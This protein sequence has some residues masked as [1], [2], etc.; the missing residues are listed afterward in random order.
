MRILINEQLSEH[1]YKTPEGYLICTD[2]IIARTGKQEYRKNEIFADS[3]DDSVIELDRPANEVFSEKTIA[4]FENKPLVNEHPNEDV[5]TEN[6]KDYAVGFIRDVHKG[7]VNGQDVLLA[8]LVFTDKEAIE[9]IESG[10]KNELSCGYDC[11]IV[12][13]A[14]PKQINIR[15]NHVALCERGRAGIAKIVDS[16]KDAE[17]IEGRT[18]T[19]KGGTKLKIKKII[20]SY[21]DYNGE[22]A[23]KIYY[24]YETAS[25][26]TGSAE[27]NS[28]DFFNMM[29]DTT[30]DS[31]KDDRYII[32]RK[33]GAGEEIYSSDNKQDVLDELESLG[34]NYMVYD[35]KTKKTYSIKEFKSTNDSVNDA[36]FTPK[37]M[38]QINHYADISS[39][40]KQEI[41]DAIM[42]LYN[43][44]IYADFDDCVEE[45][46]NNIIN[47]NYLLDSVN[48]IEIKLENGTVI[49]PQQRRDITEEIFDI[50]K[51]YHQK[52][53]DFVEIKNE[54]DIYIRNAY[55]RRASDRELEEAIEKAYK[56]FGYSLDDSI[57][58]KDIKSFF[59][60]CSVDG[61]Y[62]V[63]ADPNKIEKL[64]PKKVW[65]LER[66]GG[67]FIDMSGGQMKYFNKEQGNPDTAKDYVN[68][69]PSMNL[70]DSIQDVNPRSGESKEDFI[71]RFMSE[72][73]NEYPDEKQRL[74]VAYSYWEKGK[75]KDSM[76]KDYAVEVLTSDGR[77]YD[78]VKINY[79][80]SYDSERILREFYSKHPEYKDDIYKVQIVQDSVKDNSINDK[81]SYANYYNGNEFV[82]KI[83][84]L[85]YRNLK[86]E[87]NVALLGLKEDILVISKKYMSKEYLSENNL[88]DIKNLLE[89]EVNVKNVRY[90][91]PGTSN[92]EVS[93]N[94]IKFVGYN[95]TLRKDSLT[96]YER[97]LCD[98]MLENTYERGMTPERLWRKMI[99]YGSEYNS[100]ATHK[101]EDVL[102]YFEEEIENGMYDSIKD[103]KI[104]D[105]SVRCSVTNA[106]TA[107]RICAK[108]RCQLSMINYF[109]RI[110]AY[111]VALTGTRESIIS[112]LKD[113]DESGLLLMYPKG[114]EYA[115]DDATPYEEQDEE[116][117]KSEERIDDGGFQEIGNFWRNLARKN[118]ISS[119]QMDDIYI[120]FLKT[121]VYQNWPKKDDMDII[122]SETM[123]TEFMKFFKK[124]TGKDLITDS[125]KDSLSYSDI[126][127]IEDAI[128]WVKRKGKDL[129]VKNVLEQIQK[130][131]SGFIGSNRND[132]INY[133]KSEKHITDSIQ[134][135]V[136]L[137]AKS[138]DYLEEQI[139]RYRK[140]Y[141]NWKF[142]E[143]RKER[144]LYRVDVIKDSINDYTP[145]MTYP[146][147]GEKEW[148]VDVD[149]NDFELSWG[150]PTK[151]QAEKYAKSL[152]GKHTIKIYEK[153]LNGKQFAP[154]SNRKPT[155]SSEQML[156]EKFGK[157][158]L[159]KDSVDDAAPGVD[160]G[161]FNKITQNEHVTKEVTK[162]NEIARKYNANKRTMYQVILFWTGKDD[163]AYDLTQ[164]LNIRDSKAHKMVKVV[165]AIQQHQDSKLKDDYSGFLGNYG[166]GYL[167]GSGDYE[168]WY[169]KDKDDIQTFNKVVERIRKE[170]PSFV[171]SSIKS[172]GNPR[173]YI[174]KSKYGVKDSKLKDEVMSINVDLTNTKVSKYDIYYTVTQALKYRV[175]A[176]RI[177]EGKYILTGEKDDLKYFFYCLNLDSSKYIKDSKVQDGDIENKYKE[178]IKYY[179]N[180]MGYSDVRAKEET[181]R[182]INQFMK[183]KSISREQAIKKYY[184]QL[185]DSVKDSKA[186]DA[187]VL[188]KEQTVELLGKIA[189]KNNAILKVKIENDGR[190][191][192]GFIPK[193]KNIDS[194]KFAKTIESQ[195]PNI[196]IRGFWGYYHFG[197]EAF[198]MYTDKNTF[199]NIL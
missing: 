50:V 71:S 29:K 74:A 21:S 194:Y 107:Q 195:V 143:I 3:D 70:L 18:Y 156:R 43:R 188:T 69:F 103:S 73:E 192:A 165:K 127:V 105:A 153:E 4:S 96:R 198:E 78:K 87:V 25:G 31:I 67:N 63:S 125:V 1:K 55:N 173:I 197:T 111:A 154:T 5:N 139:K 163:V 77:L 126:E 98:Y 84:R 17:L 175:K 115:F 191:F 48:D 151:E 95:D 52:G 24:D 180:D 94:I 38:R 37:Q 172:D 146:K 189:S 91:N 13:E 116:L 199:N 88:K 169:Y 137:S 185:Y 7:T 60:K 177:S 83:E 85:I 99:S 92:A 53:Y 81:I 193:D 35:N 179:T 196:F 184:T 167:K 145:R 141:P 140:L 182:A 147:Q 157:K 15:G 26:K 110:D 119:Q 150:W 97:E 148:Y 133:L 12:D 8:N 136:E 79:N 40:D 19:T 86:L 134:D 57:D 16:I 54:V 187:N 104:K 162:L 22:A 14:N 56:K 158:W 30:R 33:S 36:Q 89:R 121:P 183:E 128:Y 90:S 49:K 27:C 142:G 23:L 159:P 114:W 45:V 129:T 62:Y 160:E 47:G 171:V 34:R 124:K 68:Q 51:K 100:V 72:T 20:A 166:F 176:K 132:I 149:N 131:M 65:I 80:G 170:Y 120:A 130:S 112:S 11:D 61:T 155:K 174:Q 2:A 186:K 113:L 42:K 118:N 109:S 122:Y 6:Y 152:T 39:F 108:Y 161:I 135:A 190:M 101:K 46:L 76:I 64:N 32:M 144:G 93:A 10:R 41:I 44:H 117:K 58:D 106:A 181:E 9:D 75:G 123:F 164:K 82:D 28:V 178:I 102:D 138:I 59:Y 66:K 168:Y